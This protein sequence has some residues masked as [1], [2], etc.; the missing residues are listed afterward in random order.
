[1]A[2]KR[3]ALKAENWAQKSAEQ[4]VVKKVEMKAD[5]KAAE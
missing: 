1:M 5:Q 2:E 4:M 3:V